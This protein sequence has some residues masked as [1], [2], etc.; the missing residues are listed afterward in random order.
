MKKIVRGKFTDGSYVQRNNGHL[1]EHYTTADE[2]SFPLRVKSYGTAGFRRG[3]ATSYPQARIGLLF[4]RRGSS[5]KQA[6]VHLA[7]SLS[8]DPLCDAVT[9]I[10]GPDS[11][12]TIG[13]SG[14][15]SYDSMTGD[16]SCV[17]TTR[18]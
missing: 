15:A 14:F 12:S 4:L 5:V 1:A 13:L 8:L 18:T 9:D 6:A 3:I 17:D 7:I 11:Q 2:C 16:D 10:L